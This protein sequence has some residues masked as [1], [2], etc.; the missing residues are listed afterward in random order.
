VI[1][2]VRGF[3]YR[4]QQ[5]A[6]GAEIDLRNLRPTQEMIQAAKKA[7]DAWTTTYHELT[8]AADEAAS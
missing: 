6:F 8:A 2:R 4:A 5:S 7:M 3:L 1:C